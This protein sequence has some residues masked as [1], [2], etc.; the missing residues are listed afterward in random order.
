MLAN[1]EAG[2]TFPEPPRGDAYEVSGSISYGMGGLVG[3]DPAKGQGVRGPR[4]YDAVPSDVDS[5]VFMLPSS[6]SSP[7]DRTWEL[8]WEVADLPDGG[9]PYGLSLD[10]TFC[11]AERPDGGSS[12]TSVSTGSAGAPLTLAYRGEPQ[13]AWHSPAGG[14]GD[15]QPLYS[16]VREDG[17]TRVTVLPYACACFE[18]RFLRGGTLTV[19]VSAV[20]RM[21]YGQAGYTL[22]TAYTRYPRTYSTLDGGT[23]SCPR[24]DPDAG[25]PGCVFTR[26]P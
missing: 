1:D 25:V 16:L 3:H 9:M 18:P 24:P 12:C 19:S 7:M 17:V 20:D 2:V 8:Q 5:Y 26:Q 21:D 15:L 11:D 22:R 4:D 14:L 10:L 23:A 13:R 6:L